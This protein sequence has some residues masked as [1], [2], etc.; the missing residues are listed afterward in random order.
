LIFKHL[1]FTALK[2][3]QITRICVIS[4]YKIGYTF[5]KEIKKQ[6]NMSKT[7]LITGTSSGIGKETAKRFRSKGWNVIATNNL[8]IKLLPKN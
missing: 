5:A 4:L 3:I 1:K 8:L 7:I 6:R 2:S